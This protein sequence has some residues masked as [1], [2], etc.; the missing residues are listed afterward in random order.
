MEDLHTGGSD[1]PV[2]S[3]HTGR[4]E[5]IVIQASVTTHTSTGCGRHVEPM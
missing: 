4:I 2:S 3:G 5:A 1:S